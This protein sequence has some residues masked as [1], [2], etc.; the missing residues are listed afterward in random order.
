MLWQHLA[1]AQGADFG[2]CS[3]LGGAL[4]VL[5]DSAANVFAV[6]ISGELNH[7]SAGRCIFF[8]THDMQSCD[9]EET[10]HGTLLVRHG[11]ELLE[12]EREPRAG[13]A[14]LERWAAR[15]ACWQHGRYPRPGHAASTQLALRHAHTQTLVCVRCFA[16]VDLQA[17]RRLARRAGRVHFLAGDGCAS[18]CCSKRHW[19][20]RFAA[21]QQRMAAALLDGKR[22]LVLWPASTAA[23]IEIWALPAQC[24]H[25]KAHAVLASAAPGT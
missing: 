9:G 3:A 18:A 4:V 11:G 15:R 19:P 14:G 13:T 21:G 5:H 10:E 25:A 24:A 6:R 16:L 20:A 1:G 22:R 2:G 23:R 17:A 12:C 7:I 8:I